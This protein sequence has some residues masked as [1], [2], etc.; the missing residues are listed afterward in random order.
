MASEITVSQDATCPCCLSTPPCCC[1][2]DTTLP[3]TITLTIANIINIGGY[4]DVFSGTYTLTQVGYSGGCGLW[5]YSGLAAGAG[6]DSTCN[7]TFSVSCQTSISVSCNGLDFGGTVFFGYA[8]FGYPT[9]SANIYPQTSPPCS[10]SPLYAEYL[11]NIQNENI[12]P[13]DD[14]SVKGASQEWS[15]I[16]SP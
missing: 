3:A 14:A 2:T 7:V 6:G 9:G 8:L 4:R 11:F 16:I 5:T 15:A 10:C 1:F 12:P 13:C